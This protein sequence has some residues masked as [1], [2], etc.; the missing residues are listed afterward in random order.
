MTPGSGL[1]YSCGGV[2]VC[3]LAQELQLGAEVCESYY[4]VLVQFRSWWNWLNHVY[5]NWL[6]PRQGHWTGKSWNQFYGFLL[7]TV[8]RGHSLCRHA[9]KRKCKLGWTES[10]QDKVKIKCKKELSQLLIDLQ[11]KRLSGKGSALQDILIGVILPVMEGIWAP[12]LWLS[13]ALITSESRLCITTAEQPYR[14]YNV[15]M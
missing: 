13:S 15:V 2:C 9:H 14:A 1:K 4:G 8:N 7:N 5:G 6:L 11:L 10:L 3:P 12:V